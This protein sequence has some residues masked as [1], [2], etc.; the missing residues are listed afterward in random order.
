[1]SLDDLSPAIAD[2]NDLSFRDDV[3][4][5]K[6]EEGIRNTGLITNGGLHEGK[7]LS[8]L[9]AD[10]VEF[11]FNLRNLDLDVESAGSLF[12]VLDLDPDWLGKSRCFSS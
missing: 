5:F 1:M 6:L 11:L 9:E 4:V 10:H 7:L 2:G 8:V 3:V 12:N